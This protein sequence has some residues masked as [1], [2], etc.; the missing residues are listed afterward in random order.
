MIEEELDRE[1]YWHQIALGIALGYLLLY[2]AWVTH[3]SCLQAQ[4]R[5]YTSM[6]EREV[7]SD[8]TVISQQKYVKMF[9]W[10]V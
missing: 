1:F 10:S 2:H 9:D 3:E 8:A 7:L 5:I 6:V 4:Y